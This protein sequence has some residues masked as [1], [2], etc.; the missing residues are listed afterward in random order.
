MKAIE[1][2]TPL[3]IAAQTL[4]AAGRAY[5]EAMKR[6][7]PAELGGVIFVTFESGECV[8]YSE[9]SR[10]SRQMQAMAH[11][12]FKDELVFAEVLEDDS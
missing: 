3:D 5:R 4:I 9:S 6:N 1:Q 10:Y 12:R 7:A 2:G 8:V 11:D